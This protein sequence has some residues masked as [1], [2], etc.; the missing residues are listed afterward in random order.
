MHKKI[1]YLAVATSLLLGTYVFSLFTYFDVHTAAKMTFADSV[2]IVSFW[3][4]VMAVP[5]GIS[6]FLLRRHYIKLSLILSLLII[7]GE[8]YMACLLYVSYFIMKDY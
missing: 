7:A 6:Y 3:L 1:W 5:V 4:C 8:V 2:S